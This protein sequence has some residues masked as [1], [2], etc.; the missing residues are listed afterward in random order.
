MFE[1]VLD[2]CL[3][4]LLLPFL[5]SSSSASSSSHSCQAGPLTFHKEIEA[6]G[7]PAEHVHGH[8]CHLGQGGILS[9]V[10]VDVVF[11]VI[12]FKEAW[13]TQKHRDPRLC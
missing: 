4:F 5:P 12:R 1:P 7:V 10:S 6:F 8:L 9:R 3:L 11:H 2:P 13:G